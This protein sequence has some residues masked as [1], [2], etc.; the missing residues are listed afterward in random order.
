VRRGDLTIAISTG[1]ASPALAVRLRER[2]QEMIGEEYERF[3]ALAGEL[4]PLIMDRVQHP[5]MRR[6]LWYTI[7]DSPILELL[8]D[9]AFGEAKARALRLIDEAAGQAK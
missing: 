6:E 4:R 1:G 9:G 8:R 5:D 3:V 2:L 7:V